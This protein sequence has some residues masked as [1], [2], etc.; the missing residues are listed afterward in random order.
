MGNGSPQLLRK[1]VLTL[2]S[3]RKQGGLG[4][5]PGQAAG[6]MTGRPLRWALPD[7]CTCTRT[8]TH[9]H[10]PT[11]TH[12]EHTLKHRHVHTRTSTYI[13]TEIHT[14]TTRSR[15]HTL[16]LSCSGLL[17]PCVQGGA[18]WSG[19]SVNHSTLVRLV[20]SGI[21]CFFSPP[22]TYS[23]LKSALLFSS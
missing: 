15:T 14:R 12:C 10:T 8:C 7:T 23:S 4:C 17:P 1:L 19:S 5:W 13:Y 6:N 16:Y 2:H 18:R 3:C 21:S 22:Q 11:C 9:T 20:L